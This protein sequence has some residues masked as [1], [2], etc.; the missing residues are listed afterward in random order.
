ME[1]WHSD[2]LKALFVSNARVSPTDTSKTS[3]AGGL[4]E[5]PGFEVGHGARGNGPQAGRGG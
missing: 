3:K 4:R 2:D 1:I 5:V